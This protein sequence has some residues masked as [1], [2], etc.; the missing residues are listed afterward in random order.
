M[1]LPKFLIA[2]NADYPENVYI[3]H[4]QKPR[5]ILDVDTDEFLI[6]DESEEIS[7]ES[8]APFI[9]EAFTFYESELDKYEDEEWGD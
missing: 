1:E 4:T 7:E 9:S 2:D 8:M 3:L 6:L 5:F